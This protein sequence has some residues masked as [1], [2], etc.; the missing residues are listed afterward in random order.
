MFPSGQEGTLNNSRTRHT[1]GLELTDGR[2]EQAPRAQ[3]GRTWG[4][5]CQSLLFPSSMR[6]SSYCLTWGAWNLN[7]QRQ[8][9]LCPG[10]TRATL[11]NSTHRPARE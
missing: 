6:L 7:S 10:K 5:A 1:R 8:H 11:Q 9:Q 3:D 2:E 4:A